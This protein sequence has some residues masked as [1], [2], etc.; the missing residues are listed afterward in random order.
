MKNQR[1]WNISEPENK[2]I[3]SGLF[4]F[5]M[6]ALTLYWGSQYY[7]TELHI[8]K[9]ILRGE[10]DQHALIEELSLKMNQSNCFDDFVAIYSGKNFGGSI[11]ILNILDTIVWIFNG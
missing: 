9:L 10:L 8:I 3:K 5:E 1:I 7:L 11:I 6:K 4:C 2:P